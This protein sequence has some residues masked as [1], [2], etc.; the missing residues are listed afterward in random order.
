MVFNTASLKSYNEDLN[1]LEVFA[2]AHNEVETFSRQLL[3]NVAN[4]LPGVLKRR[5]LDYLKKSGFD[6]NRYGFESLREF[7]V[8]ELSIM[9]SD[10]AQTFLNRMIKKSRVSP[11]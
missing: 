2:Y 5:Y 1:A 11:G 3:M 9:T 4:R 8:E 7:V 10:C 6:L